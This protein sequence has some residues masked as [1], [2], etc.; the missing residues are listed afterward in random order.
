MSSSTLN[1]AAPQKSGAQ[2]PA[3]R[4]QSVTKVFGDRKSSTQDRGPAGRQPRSVSRRVRHGRWSL[5]MRQE[6]HAQPRCRAREAN[7]RNHRG[8]RPGG[9]HVPRGHIAAVANSASQ[10]RVSAPASR[11]ATSRW[12]DPAQELLELVRLGNV[13]DKR[14]HELSGGMRQRVALARVMAQEASVVLMDEPLGALDAMTRDHMHDE[15]E[16]IWDRHRF[17]CS[18]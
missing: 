2:R 12:H 4:L 16:R 18:S 11:G 3:L 15:I 7:I 13:A 9:L 8:R 10:H 17:W 6:H 1:A 5:R 14:P